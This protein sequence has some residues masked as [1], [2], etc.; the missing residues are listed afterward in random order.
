MVRRTFK[1][2]FENW[3]LFLP[4]LLIA[5]AIGLLVVEGLSETT[6]VWGILLFLFLWLNTIFILRYRL[7][8]KKVKLRDAIYNSLSPLASGIVVLIVIV[9]E[10]IPIFL[11]IIAYSAAIETKLFEVTG[12]AI[13]FILFAV[14][15]LALSGYLLSS[16]LVAMVAVS[17]P[18]LY[19]L[20]A[21]KTAAELMHRRR[22]KFIMRLLILILVLGAIWTIV[23]LPLAGLWATALPVVISFIILTAGFSSIYM[24]AYLYLEYKELIKGDKDDKRASRK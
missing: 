22:I 17:A 11:L 13:A 9:A 21:L 14:A 3:K 5:T 12:W 7:A 10:C 16:S 1:L 6:A 4:L 19:P 23:M 2:L 24:A 15:M 20:V 8:N 18:G